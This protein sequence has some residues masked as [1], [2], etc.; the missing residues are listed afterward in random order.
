MVV[1][2]QQ[3][4][5]AQPTIST[6]YAVAEDGKVDGKRPQNKQRHLVI[7]NTNARRHSPNIDD[8]APQSM[9]VFVFLSAN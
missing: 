7:M 1:A 5:V 3:M 2:L 8:S 9:N 4:K 6:W